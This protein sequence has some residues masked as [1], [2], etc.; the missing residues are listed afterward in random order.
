MPH[1]E[2]RSPPLAHLLFF[3][4]REEGYGKPYGL[5]K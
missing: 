1:E 4:V 2:R 5:I 3:S